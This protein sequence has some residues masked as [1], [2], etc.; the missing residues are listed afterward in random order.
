MLIQPTTSYNQSLNL[1]GVVEDS[2]VGELP[3]LA[4][5]VFPRLSLLPFAIDASTGWTNPILGN[6]GGDSAP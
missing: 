1:D 6:R 3:N 2:F 5:I 4:E